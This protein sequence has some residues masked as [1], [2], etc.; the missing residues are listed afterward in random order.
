VFYLPSFPS[1][2]GEDASQKNLSLVTFPLGE[3]W[4]GVSFQYDPL[5]T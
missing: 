4:D 5:K 3:G 1:K 2:G